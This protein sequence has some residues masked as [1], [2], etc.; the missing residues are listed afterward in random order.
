MMQ[1]CLVYL[2]LPLDDGRVDDSFDHV[3]SA[4]NISVAGRMASSERVRVLQSNRW[5]G[6]H[7]TVVAVPVHVAIAPDAKVDKVSNDPP[8]DL[9]ICW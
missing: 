8:V 2:Y 7:A 1:D 5:N 6:R 9:E 4:L 3:S